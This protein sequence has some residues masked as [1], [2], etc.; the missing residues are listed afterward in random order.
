MPTSTVARPIHAQRAFTLIELLVVLIIIAVII[1]I[2]LPALGG[3]RRATRTAASKAELTKIGNAI[4]VF[5]N[6]QKRMPGYFTA[7]EMASQENMDTRG[8]S[9]MQNIMLDLAGFGT[10]TTMIGPTAAN[11]IGVDLSL[12]GVSGSGNTKAYYVPDP[13][14]FVAQK[15]GGQQIGIQAHQDMPSVVDNFGNPIVAWAIDDTAVGQIDTLDKFAKVR[16]A[17]QN[18]KSARYYWGPNACF[19]KAPTTGKR[20]YDQNNDSLIGGAM[21]Q[22]DLPGSLAGILGNP[23]YPYKNA[24]VVTNPAIPSVGRGPIVLHSP[25]AD[26][27]FVSKTDRGAKQFQ[28]QTRPYIDYTINFFTDPSGSTG[29]TD[30][31]GKPTN[32][33]VMEKFDDIFHSA[34]N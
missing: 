22:A 34:G 5:G 8:M 30:K 31:N 27:L 1:S 7:R 24:G 15:D 6:D 29:Y 17:N 10:G 16:L 20:S 33:D 3:V 12:I 9:A 14:H 32:I 23:S 19:L 18:D 13:A 25:G 26:G 4:G 21:P 11:E 2:V 28:L